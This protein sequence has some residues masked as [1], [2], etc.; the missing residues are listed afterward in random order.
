MSGSEDL[1]S[2]FSSEHRQLDALFGRFLE[3][4]FSGRREDA[5]RAI[6]EFDAALRRHTDSEEATVLARPSGTLV[7]SESENAA[8]RLARELSLEHVQV[9][10]LSGILARRLTEGAPMEEVRALAG[11][12][13]RRWDAH[14]RREEKE[15]LG[16]SPA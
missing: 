14:T 1:A 15:L 12:L 6:G 4:A 2:R 13:A 5:S 16:S 3:A 7:P 8:D 11:N 9:R 10:E